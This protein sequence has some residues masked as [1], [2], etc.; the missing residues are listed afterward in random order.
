MKPLNVSRT[1]C[2]IQNPNVMSYPLLLFGV[3]ALCLIGVGL[4]TFLTA[5]RRW[6]EFEVVRPAPPHTQDR[7]LVAVLCEGGEDPARDVA[8]AR[9]TIVVTN[10]DTYSLTT[11]PE[12]GARK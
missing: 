8:E 1:P 3:T 9:L 10:G 12:Q 5:K 11:T 7:A 2:L 4:A 6:C